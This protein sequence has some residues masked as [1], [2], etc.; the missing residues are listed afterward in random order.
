M[1]MMFCGNRG[2]ETLVANGKELRAYSFAWK[3]I[4]ESVATM[5]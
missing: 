4:G 1:M 3:R 5:A 2:D